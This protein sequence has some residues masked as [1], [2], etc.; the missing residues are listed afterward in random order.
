MCPPCGSMEEMEEVAVIDDDGGPQNVRFPSSDVP[1]VENQ[2]ESERIRRVPGNG[3]NGPAKR[4]ERFGPAP[5]LTEVEGLE[6][7][8]RR[9]MES[10]KSHGGGDYSH[11]DGLAGMMEAAEEDGLQGHDPSRVR[12]RYAAGTMRMELTVRAA[13]PRKPRST[14]EWRIS[15]GDPL[16]SCTRSCAVSLYLLPCSTYSTSSLK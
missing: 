11:P 16:G 2:P 5:W 4:F 8:C 12:T 10:P 14:V 1:R 3:I 13:F 7:P 6:A 15:P 9:T